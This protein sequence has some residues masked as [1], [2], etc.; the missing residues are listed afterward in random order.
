MRKSIISLILLTTTLFFQNCGNF[1]F[2]E[3]SNSSKNPNDNKSPVEQTSLIMAFPGAEG[4]GAETTGGRHGRIIK[5]TTLDE[6]GEGSF[7]SAVESS[8]PRIVVFEVSGTI[9]LTE[10]IVITN[11]FL[12]I[13]GQT[14]PGG[15]LIT[16]NRFIINTHD[17]IIRFMRFRLG[18]HGGLDND[19]SRALEIYGNGAYYDN[20]SYNVIIDH[21]SFSWAAD[22]IV[23]VGEDAY[24]ITVSWSVIAEGLGSNHGYAMF[25]WGKH[26]RADRKYSFHHN[27]VP[28]IAG[29]SP[30][31][32][33]RG[34]LDAVN[35]VIYNYHGNRT[36]KT[37]GDAKANWIH[38]YI[39]PGNNSLDK[40]EHYELRHDFGGTVAPNIYTFGNIGV[41]RDD[42]SYPNQ[43]NVG[44]KDYENNTPFQ[45]LSEEWRAYEPVVPSLTTITEMSDEY[46]VKI[47]E[48]VGATVPIRD[49]VDSRVIS[50]FSHLSGEIRSSVSDYPG[51]DFPIFDNSKSL[52]DIDNDGMSD[53]WEI[54]HG[55]D[56]SKDDSSEDPDGDGY[57]NIDVY[58]HDLAVGN[59]SL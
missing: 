12:T 2:Y 17:V 21:C 1:E 33:F 36:P 22:Q 39:K 19:K 54:T 48:T 13:A 32:N 20:E 59:F 30:E 37:A 34:K 50:D 15:I 6:E 42:Q 9:N 53:R 5:V 27:Y 38:N 35:N 56:L 31:I 11:P 24:N 49:S 47:L 58:L 28:H 45:L 51:N 52:D 23:S 41:K 29:R 14:S 16:G 46:A 3:S 10:R 25:Y 4:Y 44:A 18:T 7:R 57:T 43:W 40:D 26:T 8:G 55:L